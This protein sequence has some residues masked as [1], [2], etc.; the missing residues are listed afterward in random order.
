MIKRV[1]KWGLFR[2]DLTEIG[3]IWGDDVKNIFLQI[4]VIILDIP[5]GLPKPDWGC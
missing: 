2:I 4:G 3:F 1:W 5:K